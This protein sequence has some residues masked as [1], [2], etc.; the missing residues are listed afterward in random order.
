[1]HLTPTQTLQPPPPASPYFLLPLIYFFAY[2][3]SLD[4]LY[5][6]SLS[7]VYLSVVVSIQSG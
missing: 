4:K 1:M 7:I 3:F 2:K 5:F 6:L